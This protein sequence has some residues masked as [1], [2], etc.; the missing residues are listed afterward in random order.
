MAENYKFKDDKSWFEDYLICNP[1]LDDLVTSPGWDCEK[2][3]VCLTV[4]GF[5]L[6]TDDFSEMLDKITDRIEEQLK[7]EMKYLGLERAVED[8]AQE[9]LKQRVEDVEDLI[10]QLKNKLELWD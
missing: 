8:K 2:M 10:Y 1:K 3:E 5:E 7:R 9:I 4:N 6:R